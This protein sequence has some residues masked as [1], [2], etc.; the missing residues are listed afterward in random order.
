MSSIPSPT[1]YI[2]PMLLHTSPWPQNESSKQSKREG[3]SV[4]V[5]GH[6]R[7]PE[8]AM[9]GLGVDVRVSVSGWR[10]LVRASGKHA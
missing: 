10:L 2:A 6:L 8:G 4:P 5:Q 3:I 7:I 1:Y 9:R